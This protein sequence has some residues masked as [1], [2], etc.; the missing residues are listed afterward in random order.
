MAPS[1][2]SILIL[3]LAA[4]PGALAAEEVE[5]VA[6]EVPEAVPE[7][8]PV[9][10]LASQLLRQVKDGE[11]EEI[12]EPVGRLVRL[13]KSYGAKVTER[14]EAE[15]A[16]PNEK[17]RL[18]CARAL[19]QLNALERAKPVLLDML[20]HGASAEIRRLAANSIYLAP[21]LSEDKDTGDALKDALTQEKDA[22]TRIAISR[23]LWQIGG[24]GEGKQEL[25]TLM[26]AAPE[27]SVRD[28]A[29]LTLAEMG[30][31]R[32]KD[33]WAGRTDEQLFRDVFVAVVTLALEPTAR[34]QRALVLYRGVEEAGSGRSSDP[35]MRRGE[36]LMREVLTYIRRAY[37]DQ[38]RKLFPLENVAK[39]DL[40]AGAVGE[41]VRAALKAKNI[42]LADDAAL[43]EPKPG[44]WMIS[45]DEMHL[46]TVKEEEGA[47]VLYEDRTN[48]DRLFENASKGLVDSLDPFSQYLDRDEVQS[49]QEMLRQDYGGIGAYVG[50]R[51]RVFT[52][53]SPIYNSPA[54]KAG[55]KSMDAILEVDG[56]KT[57]D[58]MDKGGMGRVI[59]KLKGPPGTPVKVK[60]YRRGFAKPM[61]VTIV[62]DTIKVDSVYYA[63]LDGGIGY[64]R[65]TRFGER[66]TEEVEEALEELVVKRKARA[67]VFDLR[68]NPGGLLRT[69]VEIADRFLAGNRLIVYSEGQKEFSPRKEFFSTGGD[70]DEKLPMVTLVNSGSASASEIVAGALQDH[71]R[72]ILIGEK[73]YGK[74]SVQQIIPLRATNS[75]TQLRLTI[76]KYY[77]P[78]GRCIHG[79][80]IEPDLKAAL[81]DSDDWTYRKLQEY[82]AKHLFEDFAQKLWEA[83]KEL[84][85]KLARDDQRKTDLYPGFED[86]YK[87]I[88]PRVD[89]DDVRG[90]V[91]RILRRMTQDEQKHEFACDLET[92][93]VLQRGVYET[94]KKLN[95]DPATIA[96]YK[97]L[98]AKFEKKEEHPAGA[99]LPQDGQAK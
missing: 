87:G 22:F 14:L 3:A 9:D 96:A 60:F 48:L 52:V 56:E 69:G 89:R 98:P 54:D 78:S 90:E 72:S 61:D 35:K 38:E 49:T 74:G 80:G 92:D 41:K 95:V 53:I 62:R 67:L 81:E 68:N 18:G 73:T 2:F 97:E 10:E 99:M 25:A 58:M 66:S 37:P 51:D 24:R 12:W 13:A 77:L 5:P 91:R 31:L 57:D 65:L 11:G 33:D 84:A 79:L 55:L 71:K 76:A 82:A 45:D 34:G 26:R 8:L 47:L 30:Y 19:C 6:P 75:Q 16:S 32:S 36:L 50:V 63:M 42:M 21:I 86:L 20:K 15:L 7:Q 64:L 94:L 46:F 88:D 70:E 17:L 43:T 4:R 28:E 23:T 29:A 44:Q 1:V 85:M 83:D 93:E 27:K 40:K 59:T 39:E